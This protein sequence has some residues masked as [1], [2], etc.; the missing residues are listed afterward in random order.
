LEKS[1]TE[2]VR[3]QVL[4]SSCVPKINIYLLHVFFFSLRVKK[5]SLAW[6]CKPLITA[7]GRL[8]KEDLK[9]KARI[10][11]RHNKNLSLKKRKCQRS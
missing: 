2:E 8:R 4:L 7:T 3:H 6:W 11:Y 5:V 10:G 9:F 1:T